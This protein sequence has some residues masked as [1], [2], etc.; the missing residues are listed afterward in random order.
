MVKEGEAF[1]VV[2]ATSKCCRRVIHEELSLSA[3]AILGFLFF[4]KI[5]RQ[6]IGYARGKGEKHNVD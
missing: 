5:R 2:F 6:L 1:F 3:D 4:T